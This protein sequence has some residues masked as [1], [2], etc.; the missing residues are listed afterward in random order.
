MTGAGIR[1]DAAA[2]RT[3]ERTSKVRVRELHARR[4][5]ESRRVFSS[6]EE[7][8]CG[9]RHQT[10]STVLIVC[11]RDNEG[12]IVGFKGAATGTRITEI[13]HYFPRMFAFDGSI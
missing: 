11:V 8:S 9:Q 5:T 2:T 12:Q 7:P 13:T 3:G 4:V 1:K 6:E 10:G